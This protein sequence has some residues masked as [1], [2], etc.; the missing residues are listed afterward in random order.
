MKGVSEIHTEEYTS[1]RNC[2]KIFSIP[3]TDGRP[4]SSPVYWNRVI[5]WYCGALCQKGAM[6]CIGKNEIRYATCATFFFRRVIHLA[7][8]SWRS[9]STGSFW[10]YSK[11][12][13][14]QDSGDTKH[15][16]NQSYPKLFF[17][18]FHLRKTEVFTPKGT[19]LKFIHSMLLHLKI[20]TIPYFFCS[21]DG[22]ALEFL[23]WSW[24]ETK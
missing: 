12:W 2:N 16:S 23:V 11:Q 21:A 6:N 3:A 1:H 4:I 19:D 20:Q 8:L 10:D 9:Y 7:Q 18:L 24:K 15:I 17:T 14:I 22:W 13:E 5:S